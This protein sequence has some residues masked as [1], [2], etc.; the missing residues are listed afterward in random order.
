MR[1]LFIHQN[2]PAQ[3]KHLAPALRKAGHEV[4]VLTLAATNDFP[5]IVRHTYK[6]SRGTSKNIHPWIAESETKCI[7]GE[8]CA[9]AALKLKQ[10]GFFPDV[11]CAHPGWGEALFLRDVWPDATQLHFVEFFYSAEGLDVGFDPEFGSADFD[12]RCRIRMKNANNLLNL[13]S[14]DWGISPTHWQHSTVPI[15]FRRLISVI[16]DGI[17]TD[18]ICP[19]ASATLRI[20]TDSKQNLEFRSGD[21]VVTFVNRNLEPSRGFHRFMYALPS[22]LKRRPNVHVLIVG[23]SGVSYGAKPKE[24]SF[25]ERYLSMIR[26]EIDMQRVHFLG[27]IPYDQFKRLLQISAAHVYLTAPFVLSWSM[28]EAMS[29]GALVIGSRTAPVLEVLE[30]ERNGLLVD[31]FDSDDLVDKIVAALSE[32]QR[33]LSVRQAARQTVVERYDLTTVC[34]PAQMAL[35][36]QLAEGRLPTLLEE[37]PHSDL[38]TAILDI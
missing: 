28:L 34:L 27:R 26:D 30:H 36:E 6:V 24:G 5:G 21:E 17:N 1:I 11:I 15:P 22:L 2:F 25:K 29:A 13:H 9:R 10:D 38:K 23:G 12:L 3:Y 16:H 20:S 7:R 33:W 18:S 14:M 19:D 35:L 37:L 32:P 31:F 8:A 4:R